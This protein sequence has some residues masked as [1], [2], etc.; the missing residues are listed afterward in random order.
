MSDAFKPID[1]HKTA[2]GM[3]YAILR[4]NVFKVNKSISCLPEP[5]RL[6]N[7]PHFRMFGFEGRKRKDN[8]CIDC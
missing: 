7:V 1:R 8:R 4:A 5:L 6:A 2:A 3:M